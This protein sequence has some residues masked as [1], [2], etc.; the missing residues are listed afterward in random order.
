[1]IVPL[2]F[3]GSTTVSEKSP[4][5]ILDV[6]VSSQPDVVGEIPAC[7]LGIIVDYDVV[8]APIP[9]V[10]EAQIHGANAPEEA[11]ETEPIRTTAAQM[12]D[13][14]ASDAAVKA[15][16]FERA[17]QVVIYTCA[18][19]SH[20]LATG[21]DVGRFGMSSAVR[22]A[23]LGTPAILLPR[24]L[25]T[26]AT[27]LLPCSLGTRFLLGALFLWLRPLGRLGPSRR[28]VSGNIL[29]TAHVATAALFSASLGKGGSASYHGHRKDSYCKS[30]IKTVA[31]KLRSISGV[32]RTAGGQGNFSPRKECNFIYVLGR[33]KLWQHESK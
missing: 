30:H 10:D 31:C 17:I 12:P 18:V 16:M 24:I 6:N 33:I 13:V 29:S 27:F 23:F 15:A 1:V 19:M 32:R 3:H 8:A 2:V 14:V 25:G 20:P 7:I 11:V 26:A 28:T 21:M 22:E 9:V 5:H 4:S